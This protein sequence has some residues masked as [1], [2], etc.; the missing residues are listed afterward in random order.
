MLNLLSEQAAGYSDGYLWGMITNGRGLMPSYKRIPAQER[1][2]VVDYVRQLQRDAGVLAN[3]SVDEG[4]V[5]AGG[6]Q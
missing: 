4:A 5:A 2:Y 1:W 3:P 6:D